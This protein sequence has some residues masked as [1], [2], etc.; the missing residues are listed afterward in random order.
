MY[1]VFGIVVGL[2]VLCFAIGW[3]IPLIVGI[4]KL[5]RGQRQIGI[6]LT[7]TGGIWG[8]AAVGLIALAAFL[9]RGQ[10]FDYQ[11]KDFEPSKYEGQVGRIVVLCD[12]EVELFVS[13][14][15]DE[16]LRLKVSDQTAQAPAK[17]L[18][19]D[20]YTVRE[21]ADDGSRWK[22]YGHFYG[23]EKRLTVESDADVKL[24]IGPPLKAKLDVGLS[25]N[26]ANIGL[27]ISDT[28]GG[29]CWLHRADSDATVRF[30]ALSRSGEKLW[31]G[32]LEPG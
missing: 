23:R 29:Y 1:M 28:A 18:R 32:T 14:E 26:R 27:S 21:D 16:Q 20:S 8:L 25:K 5:R 17:R 2:V 3:L 12:G 7:I 19:I 31:E 10:M 4:V 15:G 22:L 9:G 30:V 24:E 11:V 6:A 13:G